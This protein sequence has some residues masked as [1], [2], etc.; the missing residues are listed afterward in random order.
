MEIGECSKNAD[1]RQASDSKVITPLV[2]KEDSK[3]ESCASAS[4]AGCGKRNQQ[5]GNEIPPQVSYH[6][7]KH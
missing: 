1:G 2:L 5:R 4:Q 7:Q 3:Q 6:N